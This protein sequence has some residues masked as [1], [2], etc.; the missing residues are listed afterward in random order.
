MHT[1]C[2]QLLLS[3]NITQS[4]S[5]LI[6]KKKEKKNSTLES[7]STV[8]YETGWNMLY[9]FVLFTNMYKH[10]TSYKSVYY[11]LQPNN[12]VQSFCIKGVCKHFLAMQKLLKHRWWIKCFLFDQLH[13]CWLLNCRHCASSFHKSKIC[14][15][16]SFELL[17]ARTYCHKL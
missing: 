7:H 16:Y 17:A 6:W 13:G 9:A 15:L 3:F 11:E 2:T 1:T 12:T 5:E 8:I 14:L 4:W 10:S